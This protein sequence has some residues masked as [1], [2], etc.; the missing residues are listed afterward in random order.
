M[1]TY[2]K[3][4]LVLGIYAAASLALTAVFF[5]P[6]GVTIP[7]WQAALLTGLPLLMLFLVWRFLK[8]IERKHS[9]DGQTESERKQAV[10]GVYVVG[11]VLLV[12]EALAVL[13]I[14]GMLE[15][16]LS[17]RL[18]G[19]AAGIFV[20]V[21]GNAMPKVAFSKKTLV[22]RKLSGQAAQAANRF[23]GLAL[24]SAGAGMVL[25]WAILPHGTARVIAPALLL[26]AVIGSFA[27]FYMARSATHISD[28]SVT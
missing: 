5:V 23:A 13:N 25:S 16:E 27:R 17:T 12:A 21:L 20:I 22:L 19:A 15:G 2:K 8:S 3:L 6:V 9:L 28:D 7:V 4:S 26:A 24:M 11:P 14:H 10:G 1:T 18:F